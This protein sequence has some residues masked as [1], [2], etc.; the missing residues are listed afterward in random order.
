MACSHDRYISRNPP[1]MLGGPWQSPIW[2]PPAKP[3]CSS[4]GPDDAVDSNCARPTCALL[5]EPF[6]HR[7]PDAPALGR[8]VSTSPPLLGRPSSWMRLAFG[9]GG[10][11]GARRRAYDS[12]NGRPCRSCRALDGALN[13][14]RRKRA[15]RDGQC[16]CTCAGAPGPGRLLARRAHSR[17]PRRRARTLAPY[18]TPLQISMIPRRSATVTAWVR[19]ATPSFA[20]MLF[21]CAF[22]V[23]SEIAS[24]RP[25]P[26]LPSPSATR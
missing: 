19:S 6:Q 26:L 5:H 4:R 11:G 21:R 7:A 8:G 17:A 15:V 18:C 2:G 9:G 22:T 10:R 14:W 3:V 1:G 13:P 24:A 23:C 20:K 25:T 12:P 16:E